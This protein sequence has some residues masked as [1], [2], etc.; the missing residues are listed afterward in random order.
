MTGRHK[1]RADRLDLVKIRSDRLDL[2]KIR[3]DRLDPVKQS[4]NQMKKVGIMKTLILTE[5]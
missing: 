4:I 5:Y 2:V 3:S 1:I